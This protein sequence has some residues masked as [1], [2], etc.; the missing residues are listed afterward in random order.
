MKTRLCRGLSIFTFALLCALFGTFTAFAAGN[1]DGGLDPVTGSRISGWAV[2][3]DHPDSP[4]KVA[5]YLYTDGSTQPKE[6]ATVTADQYRTDSTVNP[7]NDGHSFIF[8]IDW[9]K[10]NGTSFTVEAY[11]LTDGQKTRLAGS[12][13][14]NKNDETAA[15]DP[16]SPAPSGPA[17]ATEKKKA[18]APAA[19]EPSDGTH[20]GAYL[21]KFKT[22]AYCGC[23]HCSAGSGL[24][25]SGTVPKE[26]HTISADIKLF[27]LG[28]KL[29][30]G[31][32][33]YT[34]EDIGGSVVGNVLD[35]YFD[36]HRDALNYGVR[37]V[38][39]YAVQ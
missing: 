27:P 20:R 6:L 38:D 1:I 19:E 4:V 9:D 2:D 34:V 17:A 29:M 37:T 5:L 3:Q 30:I 11:A 7:V 15:A 39:V 10:Q 26:N 31:D 35:L 33:I 21:G 25:Y 8:D 24:T 28:T 22:T 14:Y 18:K 12:A 13:Q 16:D 23:K 32:T 36:N